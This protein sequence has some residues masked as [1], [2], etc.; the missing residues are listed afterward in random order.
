VIFVNAIAQE[1]DSEQNPAHVSKPTRKTAAIR[2]TRAAMSA[3]LPFV[4][5]HDPLRLR[6]PG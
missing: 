2:F 3:R 1:N 4:V 5:A 6:W